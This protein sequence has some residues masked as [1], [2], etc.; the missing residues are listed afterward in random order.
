[1]SVSR[2]PSPTRLYGRHGGSAKIGL[3]EFSV[4]TTPSSQGVSNGR[5]SR[6]GETAGGIP[7]DVSLSTH[8][9]APPDHLRRAAAARAT[10]L[11]RVSRPPQAE[12]PAPGQ[13]AIPRNP[14][15]APRDGRAGA[16][17]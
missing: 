5:G 13:V 3:C 9:T 10:R 2:S 12:G 17:L 1:I 16:T 11:E 14:E 4:P 6:A 8:M 7:P 15:A